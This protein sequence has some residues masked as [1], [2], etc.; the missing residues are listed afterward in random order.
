MTR[1]SARLTR[2]VE[3]DFPPEVAPGVLGQLT[4]V[5]ETLPLSGNQD[6][7]RLQACI[8]LL[9]RG[10]HELFRAALALARSDWRDALLGAGL[11]NADWPERLTQELGPA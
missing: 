11:G 7:E 1:P 6:P 9:A 8:V 2:R 10:D 4:E 5:P 3:Q